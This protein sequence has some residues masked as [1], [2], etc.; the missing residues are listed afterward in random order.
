MS[1]FTRVVASFGALT[2]ALLVSPALSSQAATPAD[3][4]A[5]AAAVAWL[6]AQQQPDGGF[7]LT[8][9][10][11]FETTD[12]VLAIAEQAQSGPTW[13]TSEAFEAVSNLHYGDSPSG[14][15]PLDYLENLTATVSDQGVAAKNLVLVALPLGIDPTAFGSVDLV[16]RMGGCDG[17]TTLGFNGFLYLTLAQ[18]LVCGSAPQANVDAIRAAQQSNGGWSFAADPNGTD[19]DTDTT[20]AAVQALIGSGATTADPAVR[21]ALIFF[22]TNQQP[23][24]S[25]QFFGVD[26]TNSTAL[27][28]LGI[29]A[30]GYDPSTSCWRDTFAPQLAGTPYGDPAAWLRGKQITSG[31][32]AGRFASPND[33]FGV[34]TLATSQSVQ[35]LLQS[36]LPVARAT[37]QVCTTT[38]PSPVVSNPSPTVGSSLTVSGNG[39]MAETTLTVQLFSTPVLLATTNADANGAYS[40]VVTIPVETN[41]G[42]HEIVVSGTGPDGQPRTASVAIDVQG[43]AVAVAVTMTPRLT[44]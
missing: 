13:S 28:M 25:W 42:A 40:V 16:D 9:F 12:A 2:L 31:D 10:A 20:A 26:D 27:G 3:H 11:G 38:G 1:R 14:A 24:G 36:W 37:S 22:A 5:A 23:N 41:P 30:A 15:T 21:A 29:A 33:D 43:A 32:D 6:E 44:G 34:N 18:Q 17:D 35:G 8:S 19:I 4:T 39:F 7:E